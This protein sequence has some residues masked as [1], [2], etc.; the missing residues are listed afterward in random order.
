MV[1]DVWTKIRPQGDVLGTLRAGWD[2]VLSSF[3]IFV[4]TKANVAINLKSFNSDKK[5]I[6]LLFIA[7]SV[8]LSSSLEIKECKV[9]TLK[10]LAWSLK[11]CSRF[12][13]FI[14]FLFKNFL[15]HYINSY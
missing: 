3:S 8:S 4:K 11:A 14:Y 15:Y 5:F 10:V 2:S 12:V 1:R 13:I 6:S 7:D 9:S